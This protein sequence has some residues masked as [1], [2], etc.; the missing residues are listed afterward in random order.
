MKLISFSHLLFFLLLQAH[1]LLTAQVAPVPSLGYPIGTPNNRI[2]TAEYD[3]CLSNINAPQAQRS[4]EEVE[5]KF[6][7]E[8]IPIVVSGEVGDCLFILKNSDAETPI[9]AL[10]TQEAQQDFNQWYQNPRSKELLSYLRDQV[11]I[12]WKTASP[13]RISFY[14]EDAANIKARYPNSTVFSQADY[15]AEH[16]SKGNTYY[17]VNELLPP[18]ALVTIPG[19]VMLNLDSQMN[20]IPDSDYN[21]PV[22][23]QEN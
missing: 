12:Q 3:T 10:P 15:I 6:I 4:L 19:A 13:G 9:D 14:K 18:K 22:D 7:G 1:M 17:F 8:K 16:F 23:I 21:R 2:S 11:I 5:E 20:N